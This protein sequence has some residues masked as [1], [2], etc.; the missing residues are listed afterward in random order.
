MQASTSS[1]LQ[2]R[3]ATAALLIAGF[4]VALYAAPTL[5]WIGLTGIVLL[6]AAWEWASMASL[7]H[8]SAGLFAVLTASLSSGLSIFAPDLTAAY[9]PALAVWLLAPALLSRGVAIRPTAV[10]LLLGVLI[11]VP[12]HV[13]MVALRNVSADLLLIVVGVVVIADSSAYFAG[14]R[15]GKHKLAPTISPGKTWEGAIGAWLAITIYTLL[16][17][18]LAPASL[19]LL[20]LPQA[21]AL[22]WAL[23]GFSVLG[24]LFESTLKRQAGIKDSGKLLPGHGGI[25]DRIDSLTAVVPAAALFW[26]LLK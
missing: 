1:G 8:L 10:H 20:C 26:I 6:L 21:L 18:F 2:T 15:F 11:L 13:G 14:R 5:L 23:F 4:L 3:I 22:F 9:Y 12:T 17:F 7:K 24:D 16:L 19:E 25:L